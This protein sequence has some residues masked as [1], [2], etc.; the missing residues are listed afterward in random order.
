M[1]EKALVSA[2]EPVIDDLIRLEKRLEEVQLMPG[3][4]GEPGK[5]AEPVSVEAVIKGI[6][7]QYSDDLRGADAV[8]PE[9]SVV[10]DALFEKYADQLKGKD[11]EQLSAVDVGLFLVEHHAETLRGV[12]GKDSDPD[13]VAEKVYEKYADQLKGEPGSSVDA[14]EV[15]KCLLDSDDL[16][17]LINKAA[18]VQ[19]DMM[20]EVALAEVYAVFK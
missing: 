7:D 2:L 20:N 11:A 17:E 5:D 8:S 16:P 6:I 15:L 13:V 1:I 9:P 19:I 18:A 10:A 4:Q 12:Q 14:S 3:P